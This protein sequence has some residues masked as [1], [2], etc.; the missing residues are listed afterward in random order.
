MQL[1]VVKWLEVAKKKCD[2]VWYYTGNTSVLIEFH[3]K[4]IRFFSFRICDPKIPVFWMDH[5]NLTA[6][7]VD[8]G[9]VISIFIWGM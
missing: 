4:S 8:V 1:C 6:E 5:M 7:L 9:L 2:V 3:L